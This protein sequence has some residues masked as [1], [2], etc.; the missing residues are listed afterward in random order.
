MLHTSTLFGSIFRTLRDLFM[1]LKKNDLK[2]FFLISSIQIEK[3]FKIFL[4]K[5]YK[6]RRVQPL[7]ASLWFSHMVGWRTWFRENQSSERKIKNMLIIYILYWFSVD[8]V[9]YFFAFLATRK[10][11]LNFLLQF[12]SPNY[13]LLLLIIIEQ[14]IILTKWPVN[15][16]TLVLRISIPNLKLIR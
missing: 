8:E 9:F 5:K 13:M 7:R 6:T 10:K 1:Q 11:F 16:K 12:L 14:N 3:R 15:W 2:V 4:T